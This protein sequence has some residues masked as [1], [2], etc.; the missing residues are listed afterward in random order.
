[1]ETVL[2]AER[3]DTG[4]LVESPG[5][6][7]K[8]SQEVP[9][10]KI[11]TKCGIWKALKEFHNNP[12]TKDGKNSQCKFCSQLAAGNLRAQNLADWYDFLSLKMKCHICGYARCKAA[13]DFHHRNPMTK[14]FQIPQWMRQHSVTEEGKRILLTELA[15]CDILCCRCHKEVHWYQNHMKEENDG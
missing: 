11:C 2:T 5:A 4:S 15:K 6:T 8:G 12:C 10:G 7:A 13:L 3:H 9:P 14:K 1:M